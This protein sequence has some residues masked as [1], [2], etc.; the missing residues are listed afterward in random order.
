MHAVEQKRTEHRH[1]RARGVQSTAPRAVNNKPALSLRKVNGLFFFSSRGRGHGDETR[2]ATNGRGFLARAAELVRCRCRGRDC[3]PSC[4]CRG[5]T[6]I[7]HVRCTTASSVYP[8][9]H[10]HYAPPPPPHPAAAIQRIFRTVYPGRENAT[11]GTRRRLAN[12]RLPA[13]KIPG[14]F[15]S[16]TVISHDVRRGP[17]N[18]S[19]PSNP[20]SLPSPPYTNDNTIQQHPLAV[21]ALAPR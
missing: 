5:H 20:S 17:S 11:P 9:S 1:S 6:R 19:K 7:G 15:L 4:R 13:F 12:F 3:Y 18:Q 2:A 8:V 10:S 21:A 14:A 16:W